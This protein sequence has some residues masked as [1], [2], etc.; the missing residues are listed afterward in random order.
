[1]LMRFS[2][3]LLVSVANIAS[4]AMLDTS[5]ITQ[6]PTPQARNCPRHRSEFRPCPRCVQRRLE[7]RVSREQRKLCVVCGRRA[8]VFGR[9]SCKSCLERNA[10]KSA[11]ITRERSAKNLCLTSGCANRAKAGRKL[12]ERHLL[13]MIKASKERRAVQILKGQCVNNCGRR[14]EFPPHQRCLICET[15]LRAQRGL[16]PIPRY[17]RNN[18]KEGLKLYRLEE[19]RTFLRSYLR[20]VSEIEQRVIRL[21]YGLDDGIRRNLTVTSSEMGFSRERARQVHDKGM[22][23]I[24]A[25]PVETPV[26]L[27]SIKDRLRKYPERLNQRARARQIVARKIKAGRLLRQPCHKCGAAK[28]D[29]HHT[30]YSQPLKVEWLCPRCHKQAHRQDRTLLN[31]LSKTA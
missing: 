27:L 29:A 16:E 6:T 30:D 18:I 31:S 12:C 25:V 19:S 23:R 22:V 2:L 20:L 1:M 10:T 8:M 28:A 11:Q 5:L 9:V 17:I 7:R 15:H 21:V 14:V 13:A 24:F 3:Q 26:A 4:F